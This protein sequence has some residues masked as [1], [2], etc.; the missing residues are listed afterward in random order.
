[1]PFGLR[2]KPKKDLYW[3]INKETGK[4]FSKEPMPKEKAEAQMRALY[5][6]V[7]VEGGIKYAK[8]GYTQIPFYDE[9]DIVPSP[10]N[11]I[12]YPMD[13]SGI[14]DPLKRLYK[15]VKD[16]GAAVLTGTNYVGP[17]NRLDEEYLR[18]N[19]PMDKIDEGAMR[20]DLEYSR[21][22]KLRKAGASKEEVARL[23]RESDDEFLDN[24]KKH[25]R[26]NPRAAAMGY[27][28]IKGKNVAEDVVGLD[29][30]LFVGEGTL[31]GGIETENAVRIIAEEMYYEMTR[32]SRTIDHRRRFLFVE[33]FVRGYFG[34]FAESQDPEYLH[35][36][37]LGRQYILQS[38][39][40]SRLYQTRQRGGKGFFSDL[41]RR[42]QENP[43]Y[44]HQMKPLGLP[45][46]FKGGVALKKRMKLIKKLEGSGFFGD[47]YDSAK[48][49]ASK[50]VERVKQTGESVINVFRGK[51]PRLDLPPP[52]RRLLETY[53][54]RPIVRM[55]V[56]RDPIESAINTALNVISLG[57][58]N[59]LKQKYGY[60]TFYHLQLEVV[61]RLD[62]SD[63][64][65]ARFV[66]QKNEVIDV[67]P[68]KPRT[69]KT[70]MVEVPMASGH[71]MNSL[72]SNAKQTM[73]EKFYYYDAFHNNCQ[74]FVG[75][76][77]ASSG[78]LGPDIAGFIKQP[79]DQLVKEISF[80]DRVAR[81]ITDLGGIV[82]VGLQGKGGLNPSDAFSAQLK[83]EGV[84][85]SA[86]LEK[87]KKNARA[88]GLAADMLGF[89]SDEKHKLQI[90]NA[91]GKI[92]RFGAVK[93]GDYILYTLQKSPEAEK[94]RKS[95][96]ARAT[97]IKGDW[98]EDPYSP[99]SLAIG[100]LWEG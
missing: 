33:G 25:W 13:G 7:P 37:D 22:A 74:D 10:N 67:S 95:Y 20:H 62:D 47:L 68:A 81:G 73:G 21:I 96:L 84:S 100:I 86:Y 1:M 23:I 64:T 45:A 89:S 14:F 2:K 44:I 61:V 92:I 39:P 76:L 48:Q 70:E 51:A 82:D 78:L 46:K 85:P 43:E 72:L 69:D 24:I 54:N 88:R 8:F 16:R 53:G 87:A 93:K 60:D 65:N 52:V 77:L 56:R 26:T 41:E 18:T 9:F 27:A 17:F 34:Y 31:K 66:L 38:V 57:S 80:T 6:N 32:N 99:N 94:H 28:G 40:R 15:D 30:N 90:P 71:T 50:A 59:V 97:K 4:K 83:K 63:D 75:A 12:I 3:V 19:P 36:M 35:A 29:R 5:A 91:E 98:A 42:I 58:W 79:V 55:F 49:F 11:P